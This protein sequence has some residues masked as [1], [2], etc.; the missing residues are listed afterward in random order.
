MPMR[1][2]KKR[3]SLRRDRHG[4]DPRR[5]CRLLQRQVPGLRGRRRGQLAAADQGPDGRHRQP[6]AIAGERRERRSDGRPRLSDRGRAGCSGRDGSRRRLA[7]RRTSCQADRRRASR[8]AWRAGL[9]A[10]GADRSCR[11]GAAG[12]VTSRWRRCI[13]RTIWRRSG[14][15]WPISRRCRR[16]PASIPPFIATHDALADHYAIPHQLHA[17]GVRRYGFHGL[18]YEYIAQA[19]AAGRARDRGRAGDRRPSRQRRLDVR[20]EATGRASKARWALPRSTGCRWERGPGQI[21]PGVVLYLMAEKGMS[22][23]KVQNFLYRE[24]GLKGLSGVS[25][26][27]RELE[28]SADPQGGASRST[29]SCTASA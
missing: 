4:H 5:Q 9:C 7:A 12:A 19:P 6:S 18:S 23:S 11:G 26:D 29:I 16:S 28:A 13:S 14:R 1:G 8:R 10:S 3:Q 25:N 2:A 24:C 20:D 15:C 21:D 22:A 27:M 17:E